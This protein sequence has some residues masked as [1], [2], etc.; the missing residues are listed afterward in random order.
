MYYCIGAVLI[1]LLANILL[2]SVACTDQL[3]AG[4]VN[5]YSFSSS[6]TSLATHIVVTVWDSVFFSA[7]CVCENVWHSASFWVFT[8]TSDAKA[9]SE[10]SMGSLHRGHKIH[11]KEENLWCLAIISLLLGNG[12]RQR[13]NYYGSLIENLA[14][15]WQ[16]C[17]LCHSTAWTAVIILY[18]CVVLPVFEVGEG[19]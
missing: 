11:V 8:L 13:H 12:T 7:E 6:F 16:H 19:R 1:L 17:P 9:L 4:V 18:S 15:D 10:I 3:K 14:T 2:S 5:S